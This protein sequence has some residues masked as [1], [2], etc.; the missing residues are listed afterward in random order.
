MGIFMKFIQLSDLHLCGSANTQLYGFT[1]HKR[2][3]EALRHV[4]WYHSDADFIVV[5]GDIAHCGQLASYREFM[6]I[7]HTCSLPIVVIPGNHDNRKL[8]YELFRCYE[9]ELNG[10]PNGIF[11]GKKIETAHSIFIFLDSSGGTNHCGIF[12]KERSEELK[13]YLEDSSSKNV[14]LFMHHPPM[15]L[16][17]SSMDKIRLLDSSWLTSTLDPHI[18]RIQHLFLGHLHRPIH[19]IWRNIPFSVVRST[20]H[21][22]DIDDLP[23]EVPPPFA[24]PANAESPEYYAVT[25]NNDGLTIHAERFT[26]QTR[27]FWL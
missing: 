25:I 16:N 2:F 24:I 7:C 21:Q 18:N 3:Q 23:Q 19:G 14:Y 22:V 13:K 10:L 17:I 5:T 15:S 26:E 27:K 11:L 4:E 8:M 1:P 6:D 9:G 20:V 12:P